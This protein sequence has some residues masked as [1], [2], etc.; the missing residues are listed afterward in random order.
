MFIKHFRIPSSSRK[1]VSLSYHAELVS[2]LSVL[3]KLTNLHE[4]WCEYY[5]IRNHPNFVHLSF[6]QLVITAWQMHELMGWECHY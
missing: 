4:I 2:V 5:E 6:L 3:N 1:K